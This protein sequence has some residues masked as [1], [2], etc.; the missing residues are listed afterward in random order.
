M[1]GLLIPIMA[2][3]YTK[4]TSRY[5]DLEAEGMKRAAESP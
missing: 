3:F 4:L 5:M 1:R 2:V